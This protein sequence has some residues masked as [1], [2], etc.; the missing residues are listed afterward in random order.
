MQHQN[1]TWHSGWIITE[2]SSSLKKLMTR[3]SY[4]GTPLINNIFCL[5]ACLCACVCEHTCVGYK[6]Y[7][8]SHTMSFLHNSE[9]KPTRTCAIPLTSKGKAKCQFAEK[10]HKSNIRQLSAM[11]GLLPMETHTLKRSSRKRTCNQQ[12]QRASSAIVYSFSCVKLDDN[13]NLLYH[14]QEH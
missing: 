6:A 10:F 7:K 13:S 4:F 9:K 1:R 3:Q 5:C 8:N 11:P 14:S 12:N 2:L